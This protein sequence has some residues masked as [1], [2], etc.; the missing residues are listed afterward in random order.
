M[1]PSALAVLLDGE[2]IGEIHRAARGALEFHYDPEYAERQAAVPLSVSMPLSRR[3]HTDQAI[4]PWLWGL[5]PDNEDVRRRWGD[6]FGVPANNPIDLLGTRIGHDC[7]GAVQFCASDEV[8]WLLERRGGVDPLT[9]QGVAARLRALRTDE[10]AWLDF[11]LDLQFSLA[12]GQRKTALHLT[13]DEWG[14]PW[15]TTPTTHILKPAIP[16]LPRTDVNEHLCMTAARLL[17]LPA[18]RTSL[19]RFEDQVAVAVQRYDR[20]RRDGTLWRVHQEDLCQA[21][22]THPDTKYESDGGPGPG[23]VARV[24]RTHAPEGRSESDVARFVDGLALNWMLGAPDAHAKNYSLL[25]DEAGV[26]LAPLYDVISALPY[27]GDGKRPI[28]LAM[29]IGTNDRVR[30]IRRRDWRELAVGLRIDSSS[31]V[32]RMLDLA[33]RLPGAFEQA[34]KDGAV[35]EIAGD[36]ADLM[37]GLV[38]T[39]AGRCAQQLTL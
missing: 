19:C 27:Q 20:V 3:A 15:G 12:G 22:S 39:Q 21:L 10:T 5:L 31:L 32:E 14:V 24:L 6:E 25:L 28:R 4:S 16:G 37:V 30:E 9:E 38:A 23:D 13:V 11:D 18:A 29:R 8:N 26:R 1:N 2:P 34:A 36:F 35:R 33:R 17:G 7:A